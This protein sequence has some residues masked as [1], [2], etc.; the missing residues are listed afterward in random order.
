MGSLDRPLHALSALVVRHA[1]VFL[2]AGFAL[3]A[4]LAGV[5]VSTGN[6][7]AIALTIGALGGIALL[8]APA[9]TVTL[10]IIGV[11]VLSGPLAFYVQSLDKVPWLFAVLGLVL[12]GSALLHAGLQR[13]TRRAPMP[14][15]IVAALAFVLFALASTLWAEGPPDDSA[16][17]LKRL[18]QYWGLMLA[19]ALIAF[20]PRT[21][22]R[23]M[24]LIVAIALLQAPMAIYQR[25]VLVPSMSGA[26]IDAVVGTL[27]LSQIGTGAS[28]VLGLMQVCLIAALLSAYRERLLGAAMLIVC[29]VVA[30]I[31]I[32]FGE[33]NAVF[34]W[35]PIAL[36][37]VFSDQL[38]RNLFRFIAGA[39]AAVVV[40]G[41]LGTVYLAAQQTGDGPTTPI[42]ERIATMIEYNVGDVGYATKDGLN[43]KTVWQAW[44]KHHGVSDP[45]GPL[46]GHGPGSAFSGDEGA[47]AVNRRHG[48]QLIDLVALTSVL[49]DLGLIGF[50][51]F[52]AVF[53]GAGWRAHR[54]IAIAAPG[55]DRAL[56]R[57][58]LAAV[59]LIVSSLLYN[60]AAVLMPSQQ[61]FTFLV[62][63]FVAWLDRRYRVAS[64]RPA[65]SAS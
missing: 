56:A 38:S 13:E 24:M 47:G 6:V 54:L 65:N 9:I 26:P 63:G 12:T 29:L 61:V 30:F 8:G 23:W 62:L 25:L 35:A 34:L 7:T 42:D 15:F 37:V 44:W 4:A 16:R 5:V 11:M 32:A 2:V 53:I 33:V 55:L 58:C 10:I 28:G 60:N 31:P 41:A 50:G 51:L 17:G 52:L 39:L 64:A 49:W 1:S 36:A 20:P 21:I 40:I 3:V 19:L 59:V 14:G 22:R 43:R 46:I 48:G 57:S 18:L 27:E 45:K